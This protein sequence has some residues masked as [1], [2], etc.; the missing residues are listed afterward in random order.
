MGRNVIQLE[1]CVPVA[2]VAD[3]AI[4]ARDGAVTI[5]WELFPPEEYTVTQ[6][7]YDTMTTLMASAFRGLP[8]WTMVHKQDIY[9]KRRYHSDSGG[10]FLDDCF[11]AHFEGREYL[12]H[13]QYLWFTFNPAI[14]GR[15]GA[16]KGTLQGAAGGIR[17]S[18][19]ADARRRSLP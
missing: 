14:P 15:S 13:R 4:V 17:V 10:Q 11:S 18:S 1:Q 8:E 5:G 2:F 12:E 9:R 19:R 3:G 6:E 7:Q 16:M